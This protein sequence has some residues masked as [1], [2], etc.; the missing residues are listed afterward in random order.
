M[1]GTRRYLIRAPLSQIVAIHA[2]L[3]RF[4]SGNRFDGTRDEAT[5]PARLPS[6]LQPRVHDLIPDSRMARHPQ[7]ENPMTLH[8]PG[9]LRSLVVCL[10]LIFLPSVLQAQTSPS[11]DGTTGVLRL[12]VVDVPGTG[13]VNATLGLSSQNPIQFTLQSASVLTSPPAVDNG[14]P[15]VVNGNTLYI[16]RVQVGSEF[17][18]LNMGVVSGDPIIFGNLQVV[19]VVPAATPTP[20][21]TPAPTPTPTPTPDPAAASN[22]RG[23]TQYAAQCAS[24][25]GSNG[26]GG[27][28]GPSVV[29]S[30]F[31]SFA[32]LRTKI[33]TTMPQGNP[34]AC[35]DTASS[36]CA[37]DVANYIINVLRK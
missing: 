26:Q 1:T 9:L 11:F 16:P 28:L 34:S 20:S 37:T 32:T 22:A 2:R 29:D 8:S 24:C 35:A 18:E 3:M 7:E 30:A 10:W 33:S 31:T 19:S 6:K 17:Y 12:P 4:C 27:A 21:P 15:R 36:T 23:Q 13:V 14:T 25:H 5:E